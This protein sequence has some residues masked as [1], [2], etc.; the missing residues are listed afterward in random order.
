MIRCPE[1]SEAGEKKERQGRDRRQL[2]SGS[3]AFKDG[4]ESG[5]LEMAAT[6]A[7]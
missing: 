1:I 4:A 6:M 7:R 5:R 2:G 3:E